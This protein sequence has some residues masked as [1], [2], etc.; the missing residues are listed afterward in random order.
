MVAPERTEKGR[1][2]GPF[3]FAQCEMDIILD[4]LLH[5]CWQGCSPAIPK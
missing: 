4:L 1:I 5:P 3:S 2:A